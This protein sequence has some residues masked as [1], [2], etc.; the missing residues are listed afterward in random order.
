MEF[1]RMSCSSLSLRISLVLMNWIE[2]EN[3][4]ICEIEN[5]LKCM[6]YS[7]IIEMFE[8]IENEG[9]EGVKKKKYYLLD[10]RGT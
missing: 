5:E 3:K 9:W 10:I 4:L 2:R 8:L 7:R 1:P 6:F